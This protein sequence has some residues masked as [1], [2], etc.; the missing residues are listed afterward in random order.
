MQLELANDGTWSVGDELRVPDYETVLVV[1]ALNGNLM[2][3]EAKALPR[4]RWLRTILR[5]G[6]GQVGHD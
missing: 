2:T 1:V 6:E 3:V 5:R 4:F